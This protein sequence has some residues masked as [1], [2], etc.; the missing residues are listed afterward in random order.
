MRTGPGKIIFSLNHTDIPLKASTFI[1]GHLYE[2]FTSKCKWL[3]GELSCMQTGFIWHVIS[4]RG[5]I[6]IAFQML[7][8]SGMVA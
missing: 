2:S 8:L 1:L 6:G 3:S 5:H 4:R 7:C